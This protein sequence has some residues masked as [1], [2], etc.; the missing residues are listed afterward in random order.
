MNI[1]NKIKMFFK[2]LYQD[3][4]SSEEEEFIDDTRSSMLNKVTPI[5]N[6]LI[7]TVIAFFIIFL[8]WA[9]VSEIDVVVN[10][11]GKVIPSSRQKIIQSL[12]GGIVKQILVKEGDLV[13]KNQ[14]VVILEDV[15]YKA[16]YG[17]IY[18][19]TL[20][21]RA[22][23]ARLNSE[24]DNK[25]DIQFPEDV[26]KNPELVKYETNLF[27]V[28]QQAYYDQLNNLEA[29]YNISKKSL[30]TYKE[31]YNSGIVSRIDYLKSQR[32]LA[33]EEQKI[34]EL[35]TKHWEEARTAFV[36][37]NNDLSSYSEQL[38]GLHDK[39]TRTTLR[40]PVDGIVKKLNVNA[41]YEVVTSAMAIM[42]ILPVEDTLLIQVHVQPSDI[43]FVHVG[44]A[45]IVQMT[46]Y[47]YSIY[48]SLN[49]KVEYVS[50]DAIQ[51]EKPIPGELPSYYLVNIRT[52][53]NYLGSPSH[54]LPILPGMD[55][56]ARIITGKKRIIDYLMK[57][58]VKAKEE[59]LRER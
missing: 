15:R 35:K 3:L 30:S 47:D 4:H 17:Q 37:A 12:D 28:R 33:E 59:A 40:S 11:R 31:A 32:M 19:K 25:K 55:T 46:A 42:E 36:Q 54:K 5:A 18:Q 27:N 24:L 49:G 41:Q 22:M 48:G 44:Q 23:I 50:A 29:G 34:L 6:I 2:K 53:K 1:F 39:M 7:Y 51:E 13:K 45:A 58:L 21:L 8:I 10:A 14:P 56:I 16:D 43:A 38:T 20:A 57:P 26:K 9:W 52:D